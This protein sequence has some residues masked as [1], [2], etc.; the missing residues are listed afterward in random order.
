MG[1]KGGSRKFRKGW[2]GHLPG[3]NILFRYFFS[4]ENSF[5]I[6]ENITEEGRPPDPLD[7][8]SNRAQS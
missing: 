6:T 3:Y 2:P 4:S 1:T 8:F 7:P 5:K